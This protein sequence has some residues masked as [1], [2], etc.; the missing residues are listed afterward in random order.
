MEQIYD[1][2]AFISYKHQDLHFAKWLQ[3]KLNNY[4]LPVKLAKA[5]GR[6]RLSPI[7]R[8]QTD[9]PPGPLHDRL[10]QNL[11]ASRYLIVIC[12]PNIK[13]GADYIDEE[14]HGF[15]RSGHKPDQ[16]IPVIID[17]V[18]DNPVEECFP[19]ALKELS[20]ET[21]LLG[22]NIRD[23]GKHDAMLRIVAAM[24]Q[25]NMTSV[26]NLDRIRAR[27]TAM[28]ASFAALVIAIFSAVGIYWYWDTQ[29]EHTAY[30]VDCALHWGVLEGIGDK[31]TPDQ[32]RNM[33]YYAEVTTKN[34]QVQKI[35]YLEGEGF[36]H[37]AGLVEFDISCSQV[38]Y[39]YTDGVLTVAD[40]LDE[41][42]KSVLCLDY[43]EKDLSIAHLTRNASEQTYS[44]TLQNQD[45]SDTAISH[46]RMSYDENGFLQSLDFMTVTG[47]LGE[48][49]TNGDGICGYQYEYNEAG[50]LTKK[51]DVKFQEENT[52]SAIARL[53][54]ISDGETEADSI[55][56][57][58]YTVYSYENNRLTEI[59]CY[60]SNGHPLNCSEGWSKEIITLDEY[61]NPV[62]MDFYSVPSRYDEEQYIYSVFYTIEN[63]RLCYRICRDGDGNYLDFYYDNQFNYAYM[64]LEYDSD[65]N[66]LQKIEWYDAN[67]V[68]RMRQLYTEDGIHQ[69][70]VE[71]F[72]ETGEPE[73]LYGYVKYTYS[74]DKQGRVTDI[75]YY[76]E[77][78]N[79]R[80]GGYYASEHY[81]YVS[82]DSDLT[83]RIEYLDSQGA[84]SMDGLS[85]ASIEYE[86][87]ENGN[88][89]QEAT[90][91]IYG[92]LCMSDWKGYA[93]IKWS[94]DAYGN[95]ISY[96]YYDENDQLFCSDV[97]GCAM[98]YDEFDASGKLISAAFYD[99][100]G[101]LTR[102]D[103]ENY[104]FAAV[105]YEYDSNGNC[106][107]IAYYDEH[108]QLMIPEG[109]WYAVKK[110]EYSAGNQLLSVGYYDEYGRLSSGPDGLALEVYEYDANGYVIYDAYFDE[111]EELVI[112]PEYGYAACQAEYDENGNYL[113]WAFYG[114]DGQLMIL[115]SLGSALSVLQCDEN[116]NI[117]YQAYFDENGER[118]INPLYE[119]SAVSIEYDDNGN[120][121][122]WAYL[123][124][125]DELMIHPE[126]RFAVMRREFDEN[127][128]CIL[129]EYYDEN[130]ELMVHPD[131]GSAI[132][133]LEYNENGEVIWIKEFD[134]NGELMINEVLGFAID[135][136]G[137]D[138]KGNVVYEGFYDENE[139]LML[140]VV[141][142][143]ALVRFEYDEN[144]NMT[145]EA[146]YDENEDRM[147]HLTCGFFA[148]EFTY[149]ENGNRLSGTYY[150]TDEAVVVSSFGFAIHRYEYDENN[151]CV[152]EWYYDEEEQLQ[153]GPD[154]YA[155]VERTFDRLGNC[156]TVT[157]FDENMSV[158]DLEA[159]G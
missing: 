77:Q 95:V 36:A 48:I 27:R 111:R 31:L 117:T 9:L 113:F 150:D 6:K 28:L 96:S 68:L 65:T 136:V 78:G 103:A 154:G 110:T 39:T 19:P 76:D 44:Q 105:V 38:V 30:Y 52:Q 85:Y 83:R 140:N 26:K 101:C 94:Y 49:L 151:N 149:D 108:N 127:G 71:F 109:I 29:V 10:M 155:Y 135:L 158:I 106:S 79:L 120:Y 134:E 64:T 90:Y 53:E 104:Y 153:S 55:T 75:F 24:L 62:A 17:S 33:F 126:E 46:Y 146:L 99:E 11:A 142:G 138:E 58:P 47:Q 82:E 22:V 21:E 2:Y 131:L 118:M 23:N 15:L 13:A 159:A 25:V 148:L 152:K 70:T 119:Y 20:K 92:Q 114:E 4:R 60:S 86:Y 145:Y 43:T 156:L 32:Y 141:E 116:G 7:F 34:H 51:T 133:K 98:E 139:E 100:N 42:G 61:L 54:E 16:I 8:D 41:D 124:E 137:F 147:L 35:R 80:S 107:S 18:S 128:H 67:Q 3:K 157:F 74:Y 97:Y 50:L 89:L 73:L 45:G 132:E 12:S 14:I 5:V 125:N 69:E 57:F 112:H 87:D 40:Y 129:Y 37:S 84:P 121:T 63:G 143:Y 56:G 123:D 130:N 115:P 91:D 144:G 122:Y 1:F 72:D 102:K 81:E 93:K 66:D 59:S 88:L